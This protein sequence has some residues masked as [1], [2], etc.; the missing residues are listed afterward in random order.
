VHTYY[1]RIRTAGAELLVITMS[2]PEALTEYSKMRT[3]PFPVVG[4][5]E[6]TAYRAFGLERTRWRTVFRPDVL[7]RYTG[8]VLRGWVPRQPSPGEDVLQL[9]G[10][11]ILDEQQRMIYAYR[12]KEPTDRPKAKELLRVIETKPS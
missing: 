7:A 8:W 3:W 12:S 5:P 6:R 10:D 2:K 1:E 11:F 4:D 9:G